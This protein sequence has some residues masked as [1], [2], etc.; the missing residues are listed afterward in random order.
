MK[1]LS[2]NLEMGKI[3]LYLM[4]SFLDTAFNAFLIA[5][6]I[7]MMSIESHRKP[8]FSAFQKS[9]VLHNAYFYG[10]VSSAI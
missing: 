6:F 4:F 7:C 5:T 2:F 1:I 9:K 8:V 3:G 10:L